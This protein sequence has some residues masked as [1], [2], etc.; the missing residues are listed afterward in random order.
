MIQLALIYAAIIWVA[1]TMGSSIL[2]YFAERYRAV[3]IAW[4]QYYC[5]KCWTFWITLAGTGSVPT[6]AIAALIAYV[7]DKQG[8]VKL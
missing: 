6:A 2:D 4:T 7:I 3:R 1:T 5:L 8:A